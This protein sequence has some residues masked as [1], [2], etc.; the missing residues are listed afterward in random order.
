MNKPLEWRLARTFIRGYALVIFFSFIQELAGPLLAFI[1]RNYSEAFEDVWVMKVF[2]IISLIVPLVIMILL[3]RYSDKFANLLAGKPEPVS[4]S[5]PSDFPF[6]VGVG[7]VGLVF[8]VQGLK[9]LADEG[10]SWYFRRFS[11]LAY[12]RPEETLNVRNL[13]VYSVE[14]ILG[15]I[16]FVGAKSLVRGLLKLR[17]MPPPTDDQGPLEQSE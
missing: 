12:Y 9:G 3:W 14:A 7:L 15:L 17:G 6:D 8:L 1:T 11:V 10:V 13:I 2:L 4:E 5:E 16:L